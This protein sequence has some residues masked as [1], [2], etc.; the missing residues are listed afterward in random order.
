M[1]TMTNEQ[2]EAAFEAARYEWIAKSGEES[3][4]AR[5]FFF[6]GSQFGLESTREIYNESH[7][8]DAEGT[9]P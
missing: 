2:I 1:T 5:Y 7:S 3:D 4:K 9:K 8:V 6:A